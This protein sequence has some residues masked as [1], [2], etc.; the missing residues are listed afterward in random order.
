MSVLQFVQTTPEEMLNSF[1]VLITNRIDLFMKRLNLKEPEVLMTRAEACE[2]LK[3]EQTTLYH[4]TCKGKLKAY[5]ISNRRYYK[6]SE[7]IESLI[8]IKK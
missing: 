8:Q 4:W 5:G 6:R 7:L 2:F 1:D 3:I